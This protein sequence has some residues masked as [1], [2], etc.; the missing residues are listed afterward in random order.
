MH[1]K[2]D[3]YGPTGRLVA[4]LSESHRV[5]G[6]VRSRHV[7]ML[8][9]LRPADPRHPTAAE[10]A[11]FWQDAQA[12]LDRLQGRLKAGERAALVAKLHARVPMPDGGVTA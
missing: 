9:T 3:K 8:A 12:A 7:G 11:A 2:W 5:D 10:R 4:S 6:V 1:I